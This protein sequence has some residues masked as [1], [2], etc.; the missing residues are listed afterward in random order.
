MAAPG[1]HDLTGSSQMYWSRRFK[2][3][4]VKVLARVVRSLLQGSDWYNFGRLMNKGLDG[5]VR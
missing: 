4:L 5:S 2:A 1:Y 3:L